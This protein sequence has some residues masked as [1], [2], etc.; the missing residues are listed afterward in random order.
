MRR[1]VKLVAINHKVVLRGKLTGRMGVEGE[2]AGA[3]WF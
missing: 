2:R 3:F 1:F